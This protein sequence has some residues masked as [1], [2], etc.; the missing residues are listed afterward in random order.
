MEA[1]AVRLL[2]GQQFA[3]PCQPGATVAEI[4][5][6]LGGLEGGPKRCRLTL[7]GAFLGDDVLLESLGLRPGEFLVAF[8]TRKK[9]AAQPAASTAAAASSNQQPSVAP[10]PAGSPQRHPPPPPL[11]SP[12]K[13]DSLLPGYLSRP[14]ASPMKPRMLQA[15]PVVPA[16]LGPGAAALTGGKATLRLPPPPEAPQQQQPVEQ[17]QHGGRPA[18]KRAKRTL[19]DLAALQYGGAGVGDAAA[20]S[21]SRQAALFTQWRAAAAEGTARAAPEL[22]AAAQP[23]A[24]LAAQKQAQE[25]VPRLQREQQQQ[26]AQRELFDDLR[27][28]LLEA[29]EASQQPPQQQ[30]QSEQQPQCEQQ[31]AAHRQE[32]AALR[33]AAAGAVPTPDGGSA[34]AAAG[35]A[36]NAAAEGAGKPHRRPSRG[37]GSKRKRPPAEPAPAAAGAAGAGAAGPG[38]ASPLAVSEAQLD[39]AAAALPLPALGQRLE[40]SFLVL[41]QLHEFLLRTHI[42]ATWKN[43]REAAEGMRLRQ[44]LALP[45]CELM[46]AVCPELVAVQQHH[47]VAPRLYRD[48]WRAGQVSSPHKVRAAVAAAAAAEAAAGGADQPLPN[49]MHLRSD[50]AGTVLEPAAA[51]AAAGAGQGAAAAAAAAAADDTKVIDFVDLGRGFLTRPIPAPF[52]AQLRQQAAAAAAAGGPAASSHAGSADAADADLDEAVGMEEGGQEELQ[53]QEAAGSGSGNEGPG[54]ARSPELAAAANNGAGR[55]RRAFRVNRLVRQRWCFRRALVRALL[56]VQQQQVGSAAVALPQVAAAPGQR[57]R[58]TRSGGAGT[59]EATA[60]TAS[61][62]EGERQA[63]WHPEFDPASVTAAQLAA[64]GQALS[65]PARAAAAAAEREAAAADALQAARRLAGGSAVGVSRPGTG[66]PGRGRGAKPDRSTA[67]DNASAGAGQRAAARPPQL[68]KQHAPCTDTTQMDS[69]QFLGHLQALPWYQG[70]VAHIEQLAARQ[71]QHASPATSLAP[72][73]AAA[74][75]LRCVQRLFTHQAAAMDHLMQGRHTVVATS[76]ASGKSLCYTVPILQALAQDRAACALLMF[77]TKALAQDQL[78]ALRELI[79]AAFGSGEAA[80]PAVH[81]YDGDT[82]MG[83]REAIRSEAQLLITNPDM[84][85][86]SVLPVHQ[87]FGRLLANLKYVVV[88]EGH[89]Y[90]GVFGCHTALVLRRLRRLCDRVYHSQP[91]FAVTTATVANPAEH[92]CE[93]LGVDR[94][95]VVDGDG[96]PHGPK[97]FVM[98]NPPL[99]QGGPPGVLSRTE[100]RARGGE[101][102]GRGTTVAQRQRVRQ[103]ANQERGDGRASLQQMAGSGSSGVPG[104]GAGSGRQQAARSLGSTQR[105]A[106]GGADAQQHGEAL[107]GEEED[108]DAYRTR[109]PTSMQPWLEAQAAQAAEAAE[110][111]GGTSRPRFSRQPEGQTDDEGGEGE[112]ER[113]SSPIVE[114]SLLLA[115]CVQHGL[116]TIAFC[117]SRKLCELVTAYV[118]EILKCTAPE[119]AGS[120]AVYRA[121]YS[122]S[123]RR[124]IERALFQG[125]LCAVAATNA[126]ELGVDVGSLD[127]TLHLGF[128]GSVASFWQQA[129]RAGRREQHS[130]GIY[131][132]WDGPLDQYFMRHPEQLFGR[133]IEKAMVDA[134]NPSILEAHAACAAAEAPLL[135]DDDQRFFGPTLPAVAARLQ[136][137]S[138]LGRHP[139][140]PTARALHYIGAVGN[141]ASK[142][143][144]RAIDPERY[145]IVEESQGGAL[146]EEIEESKAFFEVYDGAVYMYQG[147]TYLCK[148]LDLDAHVAVVRPAD[149]KYYTKCIDY[150]DV[151]VRGGKAAYKPAAAPAG[152]VAAAAAGPAGATMCSPALVTTRWLGFRRI[153]RGT[154]EVFDTVDLFVPDVQFETE[155]AYLRL[156][157]HVRQCLKEAGKCLPF[158][159]GVHAACHALLNVLPLFLMCNPSDMGAECDSPWDTRFRPERLLLYDKHQ[160]GIGLAAA[161]APLFPQLLRRALRL[162]RDCDCSGRAGCPACVQH[163]DC[164][165]YNAVLH[166]RAAAAVLEALL[167]G[168]RRQDGADER[169]GIAAEAER[170]AAAGGDCS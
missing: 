93:L 134:R 78:R 44:P 91:T 59:A 50:G 154:G 67:G 122:P 68:L 11:A 117:K 131:L 23:G 27:A 97:T 170:A 61:Q 28:E 56:L 70:Q 153:W 3:V 72:P 29:E 127:C 102:R 14:N 21:S 17:Q 9:K 87:Q 128:P 16:A 151:H 108:D 64:A 66:G 39:A 85:H 162:V 150:T 65:T 165:E 160:G 73:V 120:I 34:D 74:L 99:R 53:G 164:S 146:L 124:E 55:R 36:A 167:K 86:M 19:L 143:S 22:A 6:S 94:V 89:A 138:L 92:A 104:S 77:P 35:A 81:V 60:T 147:R 46:A 139:L 32:G 98:W 8:E 54:N 119:L 41:A 103:Q 137:A 58:Q 88:D 105:G 12:N 155:A 76:T 52:L 169:Q 123:E 161:A 13:L 144:L 158:R 37:A 135:L 63:G 38:A 31:P 106:V 43:V 145:A 75:Q 30:Q 132:G 116:R 166:K 57:G 100:E 156:P 136:A 2:S 125:N 152:G 168:P 82:P 149:L 49:P 159:D 84:L 157:R 18:A 141:P 26:Q 118:R 10:T 101:R 4:K 148:K 7:R 40:A 114:I 62:P 25:Q 109:L 96:S 24:E 95:E 79:A 163:A 129:G 90:K 121:G 69:R 83:E 112:E 126:L 133:P 110:P 15:P 111:A 142:V 130:L 42:Q 48:S 80:L 113:R 115:E 33:R 20:A 47:R 5:Q 51:S 1:V 140:N 107:D 71:A 45:D